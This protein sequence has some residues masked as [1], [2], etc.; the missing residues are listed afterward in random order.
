MNDSIKV[1][2]DRIKADEK[3]MERAKQIEE[4][5][6]KMS[7]EKKEAIISLAKELDITIASEDLGVNSN[8]EL[9]DDELTEVAGGFFITLPWWK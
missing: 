8:V 9:T 4:K 7:D 5:Y 2:M 1:F 6:P 3:L